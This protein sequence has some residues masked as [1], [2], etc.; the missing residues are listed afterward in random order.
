MKLIIKLLSVAL[1]VGGLILISSFKAVESQPAII[2]W[3]TWEEAIALNEKQPKKLLIDVYTDWCGWCKK[4][5]N[6]TFT[7]PTIIDL[8]NKDFY[9][10]KLDAE[11]KEDIVYKDFTFSF[12]PEHGRKGAHNLAVSL[13]DGKMGYPSLVYL[14]EEQSRITISPGYKT[15]EG[16][17]A[18]LEFIAG[19]HYTSMTFEEYKS[20][21]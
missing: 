5:D 17:Q 6:E 10:I 14:N 16:L 15:V 11:Q 12:N 18:E 21:Q 20:K 4:M 2:H 7:N 9:A 13:L 1:L 3:Y 19:E 8:V